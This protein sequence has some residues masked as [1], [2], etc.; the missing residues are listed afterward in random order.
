[1]KTLLKRILLAVS[2]GSLAGCTINVQSLLPGLKATP[3]PT[4]TPNVDPTTP[5]QVKYGV[6]WIQ[7]E[8]GVPQ[9]LYGVIDPDPTASSQPTPTPSSEPTPSPEPTATPNQE[10]Q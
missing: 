9:P 5:P 2:V 3:S 6:P 4:A 7:P 8:Y 1:M 10:I